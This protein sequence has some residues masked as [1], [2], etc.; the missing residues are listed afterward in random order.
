[1]L[2][3]ETDTNNER[4]C[5]C[6]CKDLS[7]LVYNMFEGLPFQNKHHTCNVSF[8]S[9]TNECVLCRIAVWVFR[10][11]LK[12]VC[13]WRKKK[14]LIWMLV[15]NCMNCCKTSW[16]VQHRTLHA[17][18]CYS[19]QVFLNI[20]HSLM[21]WSEIWVERDLLFC[22]RCFLCIFLQHQLKNLLL[23][24]LQIIELKQRF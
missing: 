23:N 11:H 18:F 14:C 10:C 16:S 22:Q 19:L 21:I 2:N 4:N 15:L 8:S 7:E 12:R 9:R 1:M 5:N 6:L 3:Y 13:C 24:H 17:S 20:L